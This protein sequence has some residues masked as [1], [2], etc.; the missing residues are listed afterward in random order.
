MSALPSPTALEEMLS[1][2]EHS[3]NQKECCSKIMTSLDNIEPEFIFHE[4]GNLWFYESDESMHLSW[5]VDGKIGDQVHIRIILPD[6]ITG[7]RE[8]GQQ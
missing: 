6:L 2:S 1:A 5:Q 3:G 4:D 8:E 7:G